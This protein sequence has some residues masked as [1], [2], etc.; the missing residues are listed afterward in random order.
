MAGG[1]AEIALTNNDTAGVGGMT[2]LPGY[3][4]V[5]LYAAFTPRQNENVEIRLDVRNLFDETYAAR[6][7]DGIGNPTRIVALNESGRT[8]A[9]TASLKF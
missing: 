6:G 1:T 7:S 2:A 4:V 3:E 9:L 5:N 8:I